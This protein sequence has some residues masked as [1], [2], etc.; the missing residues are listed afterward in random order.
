MRI[1]T[2]IEREARKQRN[3]KK[4]FAETKKDFNKMIKEVVNAQKELDTIA[5][6]SGMTEEEMN[7]LKKGTTIEE[8]G[9]SDNNIN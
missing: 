8:T 5:K 2:N 9:S 7:A 1:K 3:K 4:R 6:E